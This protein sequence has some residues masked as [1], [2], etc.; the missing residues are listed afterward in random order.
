MV[1][2]P[3]RITKHLLVV[4]KLL[5]TASIGYTIVLIIVSL[6]N[7]NSV[8]SLGSSFDDKIYHCIAY[9][10][11]AF[12]WMTYFKPSSKKYIRVIVFTCVILFGIILELI[13]HILNPNRTYDN[14][15]LMANC[16]GV[17][18]GT[19]IAIRLH[20]ITLK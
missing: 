2:Y 12:L 8:P 10:V 15:D 19:L 6:V 9:L 13:Q 3:Q 18:L 11:L 5:L 1:C 16:I 7:L 4:K 14:Y 17:L 20:I